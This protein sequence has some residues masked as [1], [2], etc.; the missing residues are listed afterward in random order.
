[1]TPTSLIYN[2]ETLDIVIH[3]EPVQGYNSFSDKH[4][5]YGRMILKYI[6]KSR[7][8]RFG[9]DFFGS[10]WGSV[11]GCC[12]EGHKFRGPQETGISSAV[13]ELSLSH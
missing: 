13:Q 2:I 7:L 5:Y 9:L 8:G 6:L 11:C 4:E 3:Y 1:L 10:G 12:A